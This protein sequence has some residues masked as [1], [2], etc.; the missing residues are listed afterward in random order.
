MFL[1]YYKSF[2]LSPVDFKVHVG[3]HSVL[4]TLLRISKTVPVTVEGRTLTCTKYCTNHFMQL[5]HFIP[6]KFEVGI[7]LFSK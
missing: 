6:P 1:I 5:T 4:L 7:I 3:E 2:C